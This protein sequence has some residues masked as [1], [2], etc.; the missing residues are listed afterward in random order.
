MPAPLDTLINEYDTLY[1]YLLDNNQMSL[2]INIE[3]HYRKVF[4]LSCASYYESEIQNIIKA[5]VSKNSKDNRISYFLSNKAI[6]RQYHTYFSWDSSN[7][8]TFLGLFGNEFK[9]K[10]SSDI[11]SN[12]DL[13]ESVRA[14]LAIGNERNKMVHENFLLYPLEKTLPELKQL[15]QRA[16]SLIEYIRSIF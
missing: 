13:V 3:N 1:Q 12:P 11:K 9:D 2:A 16:L 14:F 15:N 6:N 10:I 8:N 4:L 5:F 7:I